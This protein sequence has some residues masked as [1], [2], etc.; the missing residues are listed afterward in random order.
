MGKHRPSCRSDRM[1]PKQI[2]SKARH[3]N[4]WRMEMFALISDVRMA[5]VETEKKIRGKIF[6][7]VCVFADEF[8]FNIYN[9]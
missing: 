9:N 5:F 4:C 2:H 7:T 6:S 8:I 3:K 1:Q